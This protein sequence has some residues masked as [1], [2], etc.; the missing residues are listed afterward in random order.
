AGR[1][2]R[3]GGRRRQAPARAGG[4]VDPRSLLPLRRRR[5]QPGPDEAVAGLAGPGVLPAAG[6]PPLPRE[7]PLRPVRERRPRPRLLPAEARGRLQLRGA[8]R[9]ALRPPV[10]AGRG[11]ASPL[12][13]RRRPHR[14]DRL[15]LPVRP[16]RRRR[17]HLG[18]GSVRRH[19]LRVLRVGRRRRL[20]RRV[21]P[22]PARQDQP[23][24]P[25]HVAPRRRD[26]VPVRPVHRHVRRPVAPDGQ[27]HGRPPARPRRG[28]RRRGHDPGRAAAGGRA[29]RHGLHRRRLHDD[30]RR[31]HFPGHFHPAGVVRPQPQGH[32]RR[33][34]PRPGSRNRP[35]GGRRG[36]ENQ[37]RREERRLREKSGR[38]REGRRDVQDRRLGASGPPF[39][40]FCFCCFFLPPRL[41]PATFFFLSFC[42]LS[43]L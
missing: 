23:R 41:F 18:L 10:H 20:A 25:P 34:R 27:G 26:G 36:K 29:D 7:R 22:G 31:R 33:D 28:A 8:P 37:P 43:L 42:L 12:A 13:A 35:N 21:H 11:D 4:E 16:S 6:S 30:L 9:R 17:R 3:P 24:R 15:G 2:E 32:R 38:G 1:G 40:C 19:G 5:R 14:R 39:F